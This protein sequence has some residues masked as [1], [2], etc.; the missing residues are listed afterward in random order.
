[1]DHFKHFNHNLFGAVGGGVAAV[2]APGVV[3]PPEPGWAFT[4]DAALLLGIKD[5]PALADS[6]VS[7]ILR[8]GDA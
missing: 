5:E 7:F 2:P 8:I 1:M 3:F 4:P 6:Y